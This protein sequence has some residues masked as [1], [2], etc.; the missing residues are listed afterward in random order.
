MYIRHPVR[1]TLTMAAILVCVAL[2]LYAVFELDKRDER[3]RMAEYAARQKVE[4]LIDTVTKLQKAVTAYE[5][6]MRKL[7][8]PLQP[9]KVISI[10]DLEE[11]RVFQRG[12]LNPQIEI[13]N[14][15]Y[16][17]LPQDAAVDAL[18]MLVV[19]NKGRFTVSKNGRGT[20]YD[21]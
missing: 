15:S 5:E 19:T 10:R 2:L 14:F 11:N 13:E 8:E 1:K 17:L 7:G 9:G 4:P 16:V 12:D 3:K 20:M 18:K 21:K 6:K